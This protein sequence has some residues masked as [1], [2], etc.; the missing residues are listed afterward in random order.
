M[1]AHPRRPARGLLQMLATLPAIVVSCAALT[2][3]AADEGAPAADESAQDEGAN[4]ANEEPGGDGDPRRHPL[5]PD[6]PDVTESP[7][8]VDAG[9]FQA[10]ADFMTWSNMASKT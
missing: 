2:A 1:S 3:Q 9:H 5:S 10:E 6:R 8:S 4:A 7:Y